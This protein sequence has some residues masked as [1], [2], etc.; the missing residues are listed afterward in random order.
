VPA[1]GTSCLWNLNVRGRLK[2]GDSGNYGFTMAV[3]SNGGTGARPHADG[4]SATAYPSGVKG[5]P[6]EI[7]ES[8]TPLIFWKKELRPGSGGNG[9]TRGGLG[10]IIEI[11][12][13]IGEPFELLA[14][15]DRIVHPARGRDGGMN[16]APGAVAIKGGRT[17]K[18][19]GTQ[20]ITPGE[21]L[22]VMTPGGG[23]LGDPAARDPA[24]VAADRDE[25]R[26]T[27]T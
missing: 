1:E 14:A 17:L 5:T 9:R 25:E 11:E 15:F 13:G 4:L 7:A 23:G 27:D 21:R 20:L 24:L 19:K 22:V 18:G 2:G 8:I 3:T 10:Q 6:V 16:G 26:L 12:S